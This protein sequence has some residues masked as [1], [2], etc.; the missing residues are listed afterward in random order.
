M[1]SFCGL[2]PI[3]ITG[4][5]AG[6]TEHAFVITYSSAS[7]ELEIDDP[8][9]RSRDCVVKAIPRGVASGGHQAPAS[10]KRL[11]VY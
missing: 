6:M 8:A 9:W 4:R 1:L 10:S 3:E 11:S 2:D 7:S 5:G